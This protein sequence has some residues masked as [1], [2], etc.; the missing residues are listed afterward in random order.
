MKQVLKCTAILLAALLAGCTEETQN[1]GGDNK[2][3][4]GETD[5]GQR[6]EVLLTLK[7]KLALKEVSTKAGDPIATAEENTISTLDLY[8][9]AAA[10]E[11]GEYT[12]QERFAYR[13]DGSE[14]PEGASE[15]EL[16]PGKDD[17][18]TTGLLN[19]KKGLFAKLYCIANQ[20][21]L[22]DPAHEDETLTDAA[23]VPLTFTKPGEQGTQVATLGQPTET[24]FL[25]FHTPLLNTAAKGDTLRTPLA[26]SGA[27]TT[28]IDLTDFNSSARVQ[29][30]FKLTRLAAR[31]DIINKAEESRF[32]IETVSMGNGRRGA[33]LFPIRIY[34]K[35]PD[36]Q[37]EEL[38]TYPFRAFYGDNAN[39][40]TQTGAFYSYPSPLNDKG[41]MILKG[42]YQVNKTESKDV[43]YQIPFTQTDGNGNETSLEINNNHRYTIAI[44]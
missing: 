2:P 39:T 44:T 8:V 4:P 19:L 28:P 41:Y 29:A 43:S 23:F 5:S 22:V 11:N 33:T 37:P 9:F 17:T 42:K 30:G 40:G 3:D 27:Y 14:L 35:T 13:A 24:A 12:F 31:F 15:L 38:I 36:A 7:N 18:Q 16:T 32:S 10:D 1:G 34:G 25:T 26:M 21:A 6:R 20:T